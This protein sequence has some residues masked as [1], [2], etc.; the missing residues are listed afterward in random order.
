MRVTYAS[1]SLGIRRTQPRPFADAVGAERRRR[2]AGRAAR[3]GGG[4]VRARD[5]EEFAG[6]RVGGKRDSARGGERGEPGA[7]RDR[8]ERRAT[9]ARQR[10]GDQGARGGALRL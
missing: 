3:A 9:D 5:G 8:V 10:A 2:G 4:G 7:E 1:S 6:Q